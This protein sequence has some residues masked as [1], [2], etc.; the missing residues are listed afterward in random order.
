MTTENERTPYDGSAGSYGSRPSIDRPSDYDRSPLT[1]KPPKSFSSLDSPVVSGMKPE[2]GSGTRDEDSEEAMTPSTP[3][4]PMARSSKLFRP[5]DAEISQLQKWYLM[6]ELRR[7][8]TLEFIVRTNPEL[9][10]KVKQIQ[11]MDR[12]NRIM[13]PLDPRTLAD[14]SFEARLKNAQ[15][16]GYGTNLMIDTGSGK[17]MAIELIP[18]RMANTS[19]TVTLSTDA[20][21]SLEE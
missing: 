11:E 17:V 1:Y 3:L 20:G 12:D 8:R 2:V 9:S 16:S 4:V 21:A 7:L 15:N 14:G 13:I 6:E 18:P 19:T 10:E 5:T